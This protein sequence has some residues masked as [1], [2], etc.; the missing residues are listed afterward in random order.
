MSSFIEDRTAE[1]FM[2]VERHVDDEEPK[3]EKEEPEE[4]PEEEPDRKPFGVINEK[5]Q[6]YKKPPIRGGGVH[7]L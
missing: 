6:P 7:E 2:G 3:K 4:E 5:P 1:F